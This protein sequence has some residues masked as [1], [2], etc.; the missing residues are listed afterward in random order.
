M[1][2]KK[3]KTMWMAARRKRVAAWRRRRERA[4][5]AHWRKRRAKHY[6]CM[7]NKKGVLHVT[8]K[9]G[10]KHVC[11]SGTTLGLS[12]QMRTFKSLAVKMGKY[13]SFLRN[14]A[15]KLPKRSIEK[16]VT[17]PPPQWQGK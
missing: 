4:H 10:A 1:R 12:S 2:N 5:K 9:A 11:V 3:C 15:A 8:S 16:P 17:M 7:R 6:K 13:Q 14:L